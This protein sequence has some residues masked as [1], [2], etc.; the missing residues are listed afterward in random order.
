MPGQYEQLT[1]GD[2]APW[3]QQATSRHAN[4]KFHTA[5]GRY[6]VLGFVATTSDTIGAQVLAGVRR[7]AEVFANDTVSS[8]LVS[9]D[10]ADG[11]ITVPESVTAIWD[12]DGLVG[13]LYGSLPKAAGQQAA[14]RRFWMVLGPTLRVKALFPIVGPDG[15]IPE[16]LISYVKTLP[17]PDLATGVEI[18]APILYLPEVFEAGF[19]RDLIAY[20]QARG[21]HE[22][23][24][25]RQSGAETIEV[26]DRTI[27]SRIDCVV[28]DPRLTGYLQMAIMRRVVPEIHRAFQF[29]VRYMERYLVGRYAAEDGGHFAA[30]RDNTSDGTAHRQFAITINLNDDFDGGSLTFPEYGPKTY[31][32]AV[33]GAVIFSCGLLH[34]VTPVTR[35]K[36]YAFLP[37]LHNETGEQIRRRNLSHLAPAARPAP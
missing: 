10:P 16:A 9:H 22:T 20:H 24:V 6:V 37:F 32:P 36:R 15:S 27:K 12:F 31:K 14:A 18:Q 28:D 7:H 21:G 13:Q 23:G 2:P 26:I 4:Y 17:P 30:H 8:F 19:C 3:F 1:P 35:G 5:A 25:M 11:S 33:G 34:A 29:D